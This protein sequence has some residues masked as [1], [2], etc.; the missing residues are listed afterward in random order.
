MKW[1]L[2]GLA[3]V[4]SALAAAIVLATATAQAAPLDAS[5]VAAGAKWVV[6]VDFDA[7]R[8]SKVGQHIRE[9]ALS[10]ERV[11]KGLAKLHDELGFDPEKDLHGATLYGTDF[12]PHT[13]VLIVYAVADKDKLMSH[14][15][16]KKD[17]ITLKTDD[18][19]NELYTWTEHMGRDHKHTVWASFPK[20]GVG[21]FAD[22][23]G[24][25]KAALDVLGGKGGL[26]TDSSL[27]PNAP[28]GTVFS[29]AVAGLSAVK[30]PTRLPM[31]KQVDS[32]SFAAGESDGE[33][34]DHIKVGMT[35]GDTAKQV[36]SIID[37]V[38]AM[39][40][41]RLGDHPEALKMVNALKASADGKTLSIDWKASSDD[42]I[43]FGEKAC[44]FMKQHH[45]DRTRGRADGKRHER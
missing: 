7:A 35:N 29:G 43:K 19:S 28:K 6:H 26:T 18:G 10:D 22:S 2:A 16:S 40:A 36:K 9:K 23:A 3:A 44:E 41:L 14:L 4:T 45:Q 25:L 17:F 1:I 11:K 31:A 24:D 30:L 39:A 27:L 5:S 15:K 32:I 34:F 13:G 38:Q 42:V 20:H 12:T 8:D 33:D 37:G 21:V